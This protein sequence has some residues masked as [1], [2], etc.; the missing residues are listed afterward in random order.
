[1]GGADVRNAG[2]WNGSDQHASGMAQFNKPGGRGV[3]ATGKKNLGF[4]FQSASQHTQIYGNEQC[5][6]QGG[7]C[8]AGLASV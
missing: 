8:V 2:L 7:F 1:M 6:L 3:F 4:T 5:G